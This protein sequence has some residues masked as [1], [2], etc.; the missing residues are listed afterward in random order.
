VHRLIRTA[1]AVAAVLALAAAT[2]ACSSDDASSA[3]AQSGEPAA[4][5][6]TS[7]GPAAGAGGTF[8]LLSY[9]VAGLPQEISD[10]SPK[11]NIPLI[12]PLLDRYDVVLTQEDFDWWAP[13]GLAAGLDFTHYHRRLRAEATQPYRTG[14]HPGPEAVG[15]RADRHP[16]IG[17]GL[18]VLSRFRLGETERVPWVD[19]FGGFD[20]SDGGAADCLAMKGFLRTELT[21]ADGAVV[22][23]YDLHGEAGGSPTDQSLQADDFAQ[24]AAYLLD[25]SDGRA[26]IVAGD[27]NLH[28]DHQHPDGSDGADI[29]IWDDFLA[30]TGLTDSCAATRCDGTGRIDKVAYRSGGGVELAATG[31][32]FEAARFQDAQGNDLSDHEPLL[33]TFRWRPTG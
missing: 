11:A 32:S 21:L 4:S 25:H 9:N 10:V 3:K 8:T 15:L 30:A 33:V 13:D 31:H 23:V 17:D 20:T 12:S 2:G 19:C 5:S 1:A 6:T 22:D 26:V 29:E 7:S 14:R 27:T 16:Q 18:G 24:L 28:T